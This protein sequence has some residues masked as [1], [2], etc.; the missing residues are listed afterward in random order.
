LSNAGKRPG[1]DLCPACGGLLAGRLERWLLFCATCGFWRSTL[2]SEDRLHESQAL[3]ETKRVSGLASLREENYRRTFD[4]LRRLGR[5]E[6]KRLL[7]VGCAYGWFLKAAQQAGMDAVGLEPDPEIAAAAIRQ[8][9]SVTVGYFPDAVLAG[10]AFDVIVFND[11][12]EHIYDL[13]GVLAACRRLLR[14][15]GLLVVSAPDSRGVLFR[16]SGVLARCGRQ[17]LLDRLWQKSYPSPH[18]SYFNADNLARLL[19]RHGFE[20]RVELSLRSLQV[21]GLWS[22]LHMDRRSSVLSMASYL[23]LLAALPLLVYLLPSDQLLGIY[24]LASPTP[25]T[26]M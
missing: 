3:D 9:L 24:E 25:A 2:S 8:G 10:E 17:G 11:V 26:S 13:D 15:G 21:R 19:R 6:G 23:V 4:A 1:G 20:P 7:D 14:P 12:L 18:L 16:A 22:R 5:L